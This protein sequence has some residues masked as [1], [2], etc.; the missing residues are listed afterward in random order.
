MHLYITSSV[1]PGFFPDQFVYIW[2]LIIWYGKT[3]KFFVVVDISVVGP[4]VHP[5]HLH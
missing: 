2:I 4:F 1:Q 3:E 5:T